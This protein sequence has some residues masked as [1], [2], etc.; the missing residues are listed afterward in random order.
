MERDERETLSSTLDLLK[1]CVTCVVTAVRTS[2]PSEDECNG[3]SVS[4]MYGGAVSR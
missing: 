2:D 3:K 1:V 4:R